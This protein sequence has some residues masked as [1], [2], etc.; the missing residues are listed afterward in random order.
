MLGSKLVS[1]NRARSTPSEAITGLVPRN[2]RVVNTEDAIRVI[3]DG[4]RPFFGTAQVRFNGPLMLRLRARSKTGGRGRVHWRTAGQES[5]PRS[6]QIATNSLRAG[7]TWQ[8][9]SVCLP[10]AGKP[11]V[12]RLYFPAGKTGVEVQSIQFLSRSGREK[13]WDFVGVTP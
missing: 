5:F 2:C 10:V 12:I 9:V 7:P 6:T 3:G 1:S 4:G 8:D 13:S 11:A